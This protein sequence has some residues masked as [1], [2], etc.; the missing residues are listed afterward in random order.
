MKAYHSLIY[1]KDYYE[2]LEIFYMKDYFEKLE[3]YF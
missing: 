3:I 1:M 2:K